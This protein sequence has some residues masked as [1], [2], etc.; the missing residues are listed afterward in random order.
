MK[1]EQV[2]AKDIRDL[3]SKLG[4]T[5]EQFAQEVGVTWSTVNRWENERGKPSPLA[6]R[7]IK[8]LYAKFIK[9]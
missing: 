4:F 3:R 7:R 2:E 9:Q 6:Q 1:K 5:Q 8:E